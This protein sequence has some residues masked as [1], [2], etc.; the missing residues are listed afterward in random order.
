M[1]THT[2]LNLSLYKLYYLSLLHGF[3]AWWLF[4]IITSMSCE[5][6]SWS[7]LW[8]T[9]S[10]T[11][12]CSTIVSVVHLHSSCVE[13]LYQHLICHEEWRSKWA[14][15]EIIANKNMQM[16]SS[17][18]SEKFDSNK[19]ALWKYKMHHVLVIQGY[20]GY[21]D[22][23]QTM[24]SNPITQRLLGMRASCGL[25]VILSNHMC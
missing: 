14:R 10:C 5:I 22:G 20:W 11:S 15:G 4:I 16:G 9:H 6:C 24:K 25:G 23:A 18:L 1:P 12:M 21:I 3:R 19:F 8:R 7:P 13:E 2:L 17:R